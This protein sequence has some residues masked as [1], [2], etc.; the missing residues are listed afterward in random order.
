MQLYAESY[1]R[2]GPVATSLTGDV[3]QIISIPEL[4]PY[5]DFCQSRFYREWAQPQGWV[6]V[7]VGVLEKSAIGHAYVSMARDEGLGMVDAEMRRRMGLVVPH[8]RRAVLI[9]RTVEFKEA[10]AA[11][12]AE[13]LDSLNAGLFLTDAGGR[14]AHAN[15]AGREMLAD[16]DIL[17][18]NAGRLAVCDSHIDP[19]LRE[20]I[21]DAGDGD[22]EIG[23]KG[24][25][26]PLNATDGDRYV[27]HVLPLTAGMRRG[28]GQAFSAAAAVF[29]R[30]AALEYRSP[31]EI[32]GRSYKLTP[33]ETRVLQAIVE[34]GG[35]PDVAG[36]LGVAETTIKT[37]LRRLFEKTGAGRQADLVKLVAGFSSLLVS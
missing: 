24:I 18:S 36:E 23:S 7:A 32:V 35:V 5:E 30:R 4:V 16:G 15:A 37:H 11:T 10:K 13:I 17:R 6:D 14:I 8:V 22:A 26:L 31:L 21:A 3:E 33:T 28:T 12:L 20:I 25:A 19:L 29:V 2:F 34:V 1:S 9:G 27:A